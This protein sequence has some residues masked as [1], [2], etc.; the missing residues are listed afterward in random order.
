MRVLHPLL[1]QAAALDP[2][3]I[4]AVP[5]SASAPDIKAAYLKLA[6]QHHPDLPSSSKPSKCDF[7]DIVAAFEL[8]KDPKKRKA[9]D[10]Y[11]V[12]AGSG[13]S[14]DGINYQNMHRNP[15]GNPK[16]RPYKHA[17]QRGRYPSSSWDYGHSKSTDFYSHNTSENG[18]YTSNVSFFSILA[19]LSLLLYSVQ[20]WRL[21]PPLTDS[22]SSSAATSSGIPGVGLQSFTAMDP[23]D[24]P[25][26]K[27]SS[28]MNRDKHHDQ[29]S[30]ALAA[31][32]QDAQRFGTLRR[33]GIRYAHVAY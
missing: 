31:A 12:G 3:Q 24:A 5:R 6:K 1:R 16:S 4:L 15:W 21:A 8:L 17:Y 33:D 23:R 30:S 19:G 14:S 11:G 13:S 25:I 32:R 7:T 18:V 28:L 20:F 22:S 2:Y 9:Y 27:S 10:L 26:Y 29:A